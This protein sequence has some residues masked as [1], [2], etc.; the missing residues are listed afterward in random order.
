MRSIGVICDKEGSKYCFLEGQNSQIVRFNWLLC[1]NTKYDAWQVLDNIQ[2]V[3]MLSN[4]IYII[5][6]ETF[7]DNNVFG[8]I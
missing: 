6:C 3:N 7:P 1:A 5:I 2:Q 8:K 4:F